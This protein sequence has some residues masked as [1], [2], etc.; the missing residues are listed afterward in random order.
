MTANE[1][2]TLY[3]N[4]VGGKAIA[5][6]IVILLDFIF[7]TILA[8]RQGRFEWV[9]L[10]GYLDSDIIPALVWLA[11]EILA[12]IPTNIVPQGVITYVPIAVFSTVFIKVTASLFGHFAAF[13]VLTNPM[14][15]VGIKPTGEKPGP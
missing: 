7:G 1:Y 8:L 14:G 6:G 5:L 2:W 11:V 12:L 4:A 9:K 3:V 15:K 10:A 13:G